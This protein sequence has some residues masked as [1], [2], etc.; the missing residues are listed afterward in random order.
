[1][2]SYCLIILL[3]LGYSLNGQEKIEFLKVPK[4]SQKTTKALSAYLTKNLVDDSS[5]A[6][7]IYQWVTHNVSYDYKSIENGKPLEYKSAGAV[8]KAKSTV[9]QGYSALTVE[10]LKNAGI[11]A[12]TVE[13][14]TAQFLSDSIPLIA[15]SDHEWVAFKVDR[16]WYLCDPTWDAGYIGRIPKYKED[17]LK[18]EKIA[19]KRQKKLGKIGK[20]K[21][22]KVK[23]FKWDKKDKKKAEKAEK[24][25]GSYKSSIGFVRYPSLESFMVEPDLFVQSHLPS[26]PEFQLREYPVSMEDFTRRTKNWDTILERE[27]GKPLDFES[28]VS[29]YSSL[30]LN[31]KWIKVAKDGLKFNPVNYSSMTVHHYNYLG[32]HLNDKFRKSFEIIEKDHLHE[33]FANLRDIN[34]SVALYSKTAKKINKTAHAIS[35]R[36]ISVETKIFKTTDKAAGSMVKKVLSE[37]KKNVSQ[38]EKEK[39]KISK[40]I[41]SVRE[42]MGKL[43][44][45]SSSYS[46]PVNFDST[47]VPPAFSKWKDSLFYS[48]L[49]IDSLRKDWNELAHTDKTFEDRFKLLKVAYEM[50]YTNLQILNSAPIY[51]SDS[52][53][54]Y[55]SQIAD[56]LTGLYRFHKETFD[57]LMY[58]AEINKEYKVLEKL[59]K[60]GSTGLK[61][62]AKKNPN[63]KFAEMNKYLNSLNYQV[64]ALMETDLRTFGGDRAELMRLEDYYEGHYHTI[65]KNLEKEKEFKEKNAE[66]NFEVL[67]KN[68]KRTDEMFDKILKSTEKTEEFFEKTLGSR[69]R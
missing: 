4:E 52:I 33:D 36:I 61:N 3:L 46:T 9:C 35:K 28:Y 15:S 39:S 19:L 62:Y 67:E 20:E 42:K 18:K 63:Y 65:Q 1:M 7:H 66:H 10:L 56:G 13:G 60:R 54:L 41:E 14:Y 6:V 27:K 12:T 51:Y 17:L 47:L 58:P 8:L 30:N 34:D 32:L 23:Q 29:E 48:I 37:Q 59:I 49:K 38:L 69:P 25:R 16:K 50:S 57:S 21:R 55:D 53:I 22:K 45:E 68:R 43:L 44:M 31:D 5:K 26:Q 64:L 2:K 40:G 24:M 11:E